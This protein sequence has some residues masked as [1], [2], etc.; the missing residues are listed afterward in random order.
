MMNGTLL[1]GLASASS[2]IPNGDSSSSTNVFL[3][4]ACSLAVAAISMRPSASRLPQREREA[5][6]SS[7]VTGWP[8]WK[9]SPSRKVKDHFILSRLTVYLSTIC[10]LGWRFASFAKRVSY[11]M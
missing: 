6:Q 1:D 3:S 10:G 4:L 8:S 7:A 9:R 2:T 5:T 11:T